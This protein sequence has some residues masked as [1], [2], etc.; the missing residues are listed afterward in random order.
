MGRLHRRNLALDLACTTFKLREIDS[1]EF[2]VPTIIQD[3]QAVVDE[4]PSDGILHELLKIVEWLTE[5][6]GRIL[7]FHVPRCLSCDSGI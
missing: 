7:R 6:D 1:L 2:L 5:L 4:R 3:R